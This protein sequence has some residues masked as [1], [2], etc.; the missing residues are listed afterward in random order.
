VDQEHLHKPDT[1]NLIDERVRKS[2]KHVGTG[3]IFLNRIPMAQAVRTII[4]KWDLVKL[5]RFYYA[6]D[7]VNRKNSNL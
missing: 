3:E 1:W 7:T 6:K 4:D 5:R 2:L